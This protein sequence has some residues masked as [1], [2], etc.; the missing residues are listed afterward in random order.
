[1]VTYLKVQKMYLSVIRLRG[2][3]FAQTLQVGISDRIYDY[4]F[5]DWERMGFSSL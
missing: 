2:V 5:G 3:R 4:C 1:L